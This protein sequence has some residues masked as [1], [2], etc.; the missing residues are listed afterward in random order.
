[1]ASRKHLKREV[2][3]NVYQGIRDGRFINLL[4][5]LLQKARLS[6]DYINHVL[7][8]G[9]KTYDIAFTH[10]TA[11]VNVNYEVFEHLGDSIA[12]TCLIWYFIRRFPELDRPEGINIIGKLKIKYVSKESWYKLAEM[13]GLWDFVTVGEQTRANEK[14]KILE[15]CFESFIGCTNYLIDKYIYRGAGYSICYNLIEHFFNTIDVKLTYE[16]L[17]DPVSRLKETFDYAPFKASLGTWKLVSEKKENE[18]GFMINH[19]KVMQIHTPVN[20]VAKAVADSIQSLNKLNRIANQEMQK[21]TVDPVQLQ[22]IQ[23]ALRSCEHSL[24]NMKGVRS[25]E[26]TE[27]QEKVI[28]CGYAPLQKDAEQ[29]AAADALR[30]LE[31][32]GYLRPIPEVYNLFGGRR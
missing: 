29:R 15:D 8:K 32:S 24:R 3:T 25:N 26:S 28:G 27:I 30:V 2:E 14:R 6:D 31:Q 13:M 16:H 5:S 4:K 20:P 19:T 22:F 9:L 7:T 17:V 10:G 21:D 1:M 18:D 23:S 12:N 11:N